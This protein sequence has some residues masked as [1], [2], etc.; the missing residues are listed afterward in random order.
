M[1]ANRR[2]VLGM[3]LAGAAWPALAAGSGDV[4]LIVYNARIQT[5]DD[6]R[7]GA[8]ALAVRDGA[9]GARRALR[10]GRRRRTCRRRSSA[11]V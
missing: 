8:T 9:G 5:V 4:D 2:A 6:A 3:G 7:P 11:M 10:G 1:I